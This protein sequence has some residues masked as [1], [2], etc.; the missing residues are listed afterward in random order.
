MPESQARATTPHLCGAGCQ[1]LGFVHSRQTLCRATLPCLL[2][3]VLRQVLTLVQP[4]LELT[5]ASDSQELSCPRQPSPEITGIS[6]DHVWHF[7][8]IVFLH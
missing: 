6:H 3:F 2:C 1:N 4:S 8:E 5:V 7:E